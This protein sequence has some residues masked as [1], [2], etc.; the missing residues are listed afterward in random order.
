L[1]WSGGTGECESGRA[2][3]RK[4]EVAGFKQGKIHRHRHLVTFGCS[5]VT[6]GNKLRPSSELQTRMQL[7]QILAPK[8]CLSN[9]SQRS[10]IL[11]TT[12]FIPRCAGSI[13]QHPHVPVKG[14]ISFIHSLFSA[15][16]PFHAS[17]QQLRHPPL[18]HPALPP[19]ALPQDCP[20]FPNKQQ[21]ATPV[22]HLTSASLQPNPSPPPTIHI[23]PHVSRCP[24]T[25]SFEPFITSF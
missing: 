14:F 15:F 3:G 21:P 5:G 10:K 19:G 25:R 22:Y 20:A 8:A 16:A 18:S 9:E 12:A 2:G 24:R 17:Y 1:F 11:R 7:S 6:V 23:S 13:G 4:G